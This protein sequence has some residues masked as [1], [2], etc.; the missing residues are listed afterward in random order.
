MIGKSISIMFLEKEFTEP[1]KA[2]ALG[3]F[4]TFYGNQ[5]LL[6]NS[7]PGLCTFRNSLF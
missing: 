5:F 4:L 2:T 1:Q 7:I 6:M 3:Y